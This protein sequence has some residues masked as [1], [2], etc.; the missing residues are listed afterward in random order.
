MF[1]ETILHFNMAA[2]FIF[3]ITIFYVIYRKSYKAYSSFIFLTI[4][5]SYFIVCA[6][7]ILVSSEILPIIPEKIGMFLYY[8]LKYLTS[9][10]YLYY[11]FIITNSEDV[12]KNKKIS[13]IF[14]IPF[15]L[16]VGFLISNLFTGHIYYFDGDIYKRGDYLFIFYGLSFIYVIIGLIWIVRFI[17]AFS[18]N[19]V[20]ALLSVYV[21]SIIALLVQFFYSKV[22]IEILASSISFVLLSITVERSQLIVDPKTGLKN[23]N[24]FNKAI[25]IAFK[26]K[27]ET[28]LLIF[29]I[30]NYAVLYEKYNYDLAVNKIRNMTTYLSKAF[31]NEFEY[32]CYYLGDGVVAITTKTV[33]Y[34]NMLSQV[35]SDVLQYPDYDKIVFNIDYLLCVL[36]IPSDF[37]GL[38]D[39]YKFQENFADSIDTDKKIIYVSRLR[40]DDNLEMLFN[41]NS[42]I[43]NAVKNRNIIL[44]FQPVYN[45]KKKKYM[46]VEALA[47]IKDDK[48]GLINADSFIPYAEKKD[49]IYDIDMIV[50]DSAYKCYIELRLE[51]LGISNI[52]INISVKTLLNP[53][54]ARDLKKIENKYKLKKDI[55]NFELKERE[56]ATFNPNAFEM[57]NKM[58]KEGYVFSLDN[59]GIGCMPVLNLAKVP[60]RNVKFDNSFAKGLAKN[61]TR[62]IIESTIKL[63]KE[64]NKT[65]VCT[66]IETVEEARVLESLNPD[67]VQGD[68]YSKPL[69]RDDLLLFLKENNKYE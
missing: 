40:K 41:L 25:F 5:I 19:E 56:K 16:T 38:S 14:S 68:Y 47:R 64:L 24:N 52:D 26:R 13:I 9:I 63:F 3:A 7:D 21:L 11:I 61:E 49:K 20:F 67:Y 69:N 29:Y 8:L 33:D 65:S 1:L 6:L 18:I 48:Y 58:M 34:A 23:I 10:I 27:K 28:G 22:L 66:G 39:F 17:K 55:I 44:E 31:L 60:F 37:K 42:I 57:I 2:L 35:M 15:I 53:N 12:I 46:I 32:E 59:Y 54:F 51:S 36:S 50:I 30:K 62:I 4:N 43:D 45:M